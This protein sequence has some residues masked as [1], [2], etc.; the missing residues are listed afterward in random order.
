VYRYLSDDGIAGSE[1]TFVLCT[2][3]LVDALAMSGRVD[4]ARSMFE[5]IAE[6]ANHVGLFA[7]QIDVR[8]G[9]FLGNF[10]Q[11]FS[12]IGLINSALYLAYAEQRETPVPD[13]IGSE[14]HRSSE[15]ADR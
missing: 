15:L 2:F 13:P 10:P 14:E 7:E 12:H 3:W 6:R 8:S 9:A 5:S 1:G 4:E 11:V